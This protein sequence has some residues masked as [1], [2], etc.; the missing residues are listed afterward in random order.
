MIIILK[1]IIAYNGDLRKPLQLSGA[2]SDAQDNT[3]AVIVRHEITGTRNSLKGHQDTGQD[4]R[5]N[6]LAYDT[7]YDACDACG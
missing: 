3:I 2:H 7:E 4:I 5:H 1:I 6:V